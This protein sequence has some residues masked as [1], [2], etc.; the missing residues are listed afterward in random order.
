MKFPARRRLA[1][2]VELGA[3]DVELEKI[4]VFVEVV[5][6]PLHAHAHG[7]G[8]RR[9]ERTSRVAVRSEI[10][11]AIGRAERRVHE[12]HVARAVALEIAAQD[13]ENAGIR[14][15]C[16]DARTR[17]IA[18][19]REREHPHIGAAVDHARRRLQRM[20]RVDAAHTFVLVLHIRVRP[21][22]DAQAKAANGHLLPAP[23]SEQTVPQQL[24]SRVQT[25]APHDGTEP[26]Q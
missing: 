4:D 25:S 16:D 12:C 19:R 17:V 26:P 18:P 8:A 11:L 22:G 14:L 13:R 10:H 9:G 15:E 23:R 3:L 2:H 6:Q 7:A 24:E 1:H 20:K 5:R 21:V